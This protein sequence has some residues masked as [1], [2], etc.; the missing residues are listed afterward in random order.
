MI[1]YIFKRKTTGKWYRRWQEG[2][3]E[4]TK[5]KSLGVTNKEVATKMWLKLKEQK[6]TGTIGLGTPARLKTG[7]QLPLSE[8]LATYLYEKEKEWKSQKHWQVSRDRISKICREAGWVFVRDISANSFRQWRARQDLSAKTLNDY[9]SALNAFI[10]WMVESGYLQNSPIDCIRN[11][12]RTGKS[13]ERIVFT[14]DELHRLLESVPSENRRL[15]YLTAVYTGLR[16]AEIAALEW[17]DIK[18]NGEMAYVAARA[19]TTKNSRDAEQPLPDFFTEALLAFKPEDAEPT[20][21]IFNVPSMDVYKS[22][23]NRAGIMYKDAHGNRRDFH[24]MRKLFNTLLQLQ[25]TVPRLAQ[26]LMR[27]SDIKLTMGVYTDTRMLPKHAAVNTLPNFLSV[28]KTVHTPLVSGGAKGQEESLT[29]NTQTPQEANDN[30]GKCPVEGTGGASSQLVLEVGVEPTRDLTPTRPSTLR[31]YQFRHPS[32]F[33]KLV[34]QDTQTPREVQ[35][36]KSKK[37]E[38]PFLPFPRDFGRMANVPQYSVIFSQ[39]SSAGLSACRGPA[40]FGKHALHP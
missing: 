32:A 33:L 39:P 30:G 35:A 19:A 4:K 14:E 12:K 27:H 26:E 17:R 20:D 24:A 5:T 37:F 11:L 21:K 2:E 6:E 34:E 29:G 10:K 16:R 31:V 36:V 3:G 38:V 25:G 18:L 7:M 13:F 1:D 22:D 40:P 15:T 28:H 9:L 8:H 23:L